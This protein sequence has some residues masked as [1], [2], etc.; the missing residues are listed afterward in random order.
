M[1]PDYI[2]AS[3][4]AVILV[5][6]DDALINMNTADMLSELGHTVLEAY[7]GQ[8]ALSILKDGRRIDALI[9]DYDMPGM[10]GVE[11]AALAQELRP[12]LP[13][14]LAT[15]YTDLP[16]GTMSELPRLA[17]PFQQ[18]VLARQLAALLASRSEVVG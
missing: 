12:K 6:D 4:A 13:V 3:H 14:L 17:K 10:S 16:N 15:G 11:L 1:E 5:V 9:T 2:N 8:E 18:D 7:S